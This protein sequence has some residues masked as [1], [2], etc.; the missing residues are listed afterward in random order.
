MPREQEQ[1]HTAA[2]G[3]GEVQDEARVDAEWKHMEGVAGRTRSEQYRM[4]AKELKP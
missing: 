3:E 2:V 4:N 1:Q